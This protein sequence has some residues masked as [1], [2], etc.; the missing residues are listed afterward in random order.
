MDLFQVTGNEDKIGKEV[1][2]ELK[3]ID[4]STITPLDAL[5]VLYNLQKKAGRG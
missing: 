2:E 5:N 3:S 4:V 1:L